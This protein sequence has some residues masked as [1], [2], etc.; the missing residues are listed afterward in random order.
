MKQKTKEITF[1]WDEGN[2]AK[3]WIKHNVAPHETEEAFFDKSAIID[4]DKL[5]SEKELRHVLIG[6]TKTGRL[7]YIAF[8]IRGKHIRPISSRPTNKKEVAI[9]E[10]RVS[11]S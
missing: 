8:T 2:R 10:K 1:D 9:Y 6:K 7:L 3:S 5:H 11:N 4:D